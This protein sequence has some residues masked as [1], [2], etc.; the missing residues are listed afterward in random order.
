MPPNVFP[1]EKIAQVYTLNCD[2]FS[3]ALRKCQESGQNSFVVPVTLGIVA[4]AWGK[5]GQ[6]PTDFENS[7][8]ELRVPGS[9][10][11]MIRSW[12]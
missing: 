7:P 12:K 3:E 5:T 4:T 10:T 8:A 11:R 9:H 2:Y 6:R 1:V